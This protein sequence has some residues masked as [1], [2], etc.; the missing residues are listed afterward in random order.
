VNVLFEFLM[1]LAAGMTA[2]MALT[3]AR[4]VSG[5]FFRNHLYVVLGLTTLASLVAAGQ[6]R[7]LLWMTMLSAAVSYIGAIA[8]LYDS[9]RIGKAVLWVLCGVSLVAAYQGSAAIRMDGSELTTL[10]QAVGPVDVV[11]ASALLG[12][13]MMAMLLGHWYL[14]APEMEI[15]PLK[16]LMK[17]SCAALLGRLLLCGGMVIWGIGNLS[18]VE[19][20]VAWLLAIRWLFGFLGLAGVLGMAWQTLQIPNTQSA[21]GLLY[22]AVFAVLAGELVSL[23]LSAQYPFVL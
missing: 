21:T 18:Q 8:W 15:A 5:A 16:R 4:Q 6:D 2:A 22:V 7:V 14:N 9:R 23:L 20:V 13:V 10:G 19:Q 17:L 3:S 12:C 1:R 11:T